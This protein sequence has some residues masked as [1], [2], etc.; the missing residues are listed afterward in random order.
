VAI[1]KVRLIVNPVSRPSRVK[2][3]IPSVMRILEDAGSEVEKA[4]T[5]APGDPGRLALDA[6]GKVDA[7]LIAGGDGSINEAMNALRDSDTPVGVIP[8]GTVNVFA[9]EMGIPL[10]PRKAA[11]AF[12]HGRV[13]RFDMGRIGNRYFLLMASYG[14][15]VLALRRNP[16]ILKRISGRYSYALTGLFLIPFYRVPPIEVVPDGAEDVHTACFAI[17]SNSKCY[18]GEYEVAPE[19]DMHDGLLDATL[20]C[21]PGRLGLLKIFSSLLKG[22]HLKKPWVKTFKAAK[23]T[24]RT[25]DLDL[26]QV[27]GDPIRP[28]TGEIAVERDAIQVV[29]PE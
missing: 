26:F 24:F 8:I 28:E 20:F 25:P 4:T 18:A 29:V 14:F 22:N 19:A 12:V 15:D 17:F 1:K 27:D 6:K 13:Q 10:D 11:D 21:I 23:M 16:G 5:R 7:V 9:R 2:R 3:A